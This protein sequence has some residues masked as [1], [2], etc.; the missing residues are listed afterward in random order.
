MD[1]SS[2]IGRGFSKFR[3]CVGVEPRRP[4]GYKEVG[5]SPLWLS[6]E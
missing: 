4:G 6:E 1:G 2:E 3:K 5:E